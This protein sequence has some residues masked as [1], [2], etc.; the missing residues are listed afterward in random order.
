MKTNRSE[1]PGAVAGWLF[2][3]RNFISGL[4]AVVLLGAAF[5]SS[6]APVPEVARE[7]ISFNDHWLFTKDDPADTGDQLSYEKLKGW[8]LPTGAELTTNA[9]LARPEGNPGAAVIYTQDNFDDHG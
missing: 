4:S 3:G 1:N 8:I 2:A 7:R 9:P 6:A 5:P